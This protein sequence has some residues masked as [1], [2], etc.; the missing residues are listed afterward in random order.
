M[1][2]RDFCTR[3]VVTVGADASVR[4]AARIMRRNGVGAVVA[5]AEQD[6]RPLGVLTDRDIV[7]EFV[8][9]EASPD[10]VA[11]RD[12]LLRPPVLIEENASLGEAIARMRSAGTRRLPVVDSAGRLTGMLSADDVH[13]ALAAHYRQLA[14]LPF[15]QTEIERRLHPDDVA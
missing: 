3:A 8:A 12:A 2:V 13:L 7:L 5:V 10:T 14:G 15:A 1:L 11:V 9:T 4:E 6:Q